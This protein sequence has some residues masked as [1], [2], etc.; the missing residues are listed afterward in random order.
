MSRHSRGLFRFYRLMPP[1]I[2][3]NRTKKILA[4]PKIVP[5]NNKPTGRYIVS[6]RGNVTQLYPEGKVQRD[7]RHADFFT[8]PVQLFKGTATK[9]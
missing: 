7:C 8:A 2:V 5:S 4:L 9:V 1:I 6:F 3:S